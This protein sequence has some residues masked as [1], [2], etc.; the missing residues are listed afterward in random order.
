MPKGVQ[1]LAH[2][3]G[4]SGHAHAGG[5][6]LPNAEAVFVAGLQHSRNSQV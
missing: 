4:G 3:L 5:Q 2:A 1:H 6:K